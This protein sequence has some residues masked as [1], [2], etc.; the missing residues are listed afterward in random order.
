MN[1]DLNTHLTKEDIQMASKHIERCSTSSGNYKLK[2][3]WDTST[4]IY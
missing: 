1:K 3:Q 2:Q 4:H